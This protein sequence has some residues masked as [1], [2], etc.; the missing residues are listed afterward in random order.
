MAHA[1]NVVIYPIIDEEAWRARR[2]ENLNATDRGATFGV[3]RFKTMAQVVAEKRGLTGLGPDP[4][5]PLIRR[6]HA[7]EDDAIDEIR[8]LRPNWTMI[9][10]EH[11]YVDTV[12][13]IAA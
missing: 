1:G 13:R 6:G 11:Q 9:K 12:N 3:G 7:L 2:P 5:S 10:C 8:R 4:D